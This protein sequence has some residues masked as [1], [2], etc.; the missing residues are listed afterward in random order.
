MRM[1]FSRAV[2]FHEADEISV[3]PSKNGIAIKIYHCSEPGSCFRGTFRRYQRLTNFHFVCE[4][5]WQETHSMCIR[6]TPLLMIYHLHPAFR[7][8]VIRNNTL[9]FSVRKADQQCWDAFKNWNDHC[10]S[11][12]AN[13]FIEILIVFT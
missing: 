9:I 4:C 7:W 11:R 13:G 10:I 1:Y 6:L 12:R 8:N 3:T 2:Y 5:L